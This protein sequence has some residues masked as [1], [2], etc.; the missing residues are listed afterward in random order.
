MS[1]KAVGEAS[2]SSE[3]SHGHCSLEGCQGP[4]VHDLKNAPQ[5]VYNTRS[6]GQFSPGQHHTESAIWAWIYWGLGEGSGAEEA[7]RASG[8]VYTAYNVAYG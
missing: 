4:P 8:K 2:F 6:V 3:P 7:R 1:R 5:D